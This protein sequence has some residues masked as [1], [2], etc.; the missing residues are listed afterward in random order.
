MMKQVKINHISDIK[1]SNYNE[2]TSGLLSFLPI[3]NAII[4][5]KST[6]NKIKEPINVASKDILI[7][8]W[9]I[10]KMEIQSLAIYSQL[11][12]NRIHYS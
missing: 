11:I 2:L 4:Y 10:K 12:I 6:A 8:K 7:L 9:P 1:S 3:L 5:P